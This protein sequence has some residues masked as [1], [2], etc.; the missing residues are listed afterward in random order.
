MCLQ[1]APLALTDRTRAQSVLPVPTRATIQQD[2]QEDSPPTPRTFTHA[3]ARVSFAA[4]TMVRRGFPR[5]QA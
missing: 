5:A 3:Q 1:V 2:Q 4:P